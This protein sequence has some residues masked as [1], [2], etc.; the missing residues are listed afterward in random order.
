MDF[1]LSHLE[2]L[3]ER[4]INVFLRHVASHLGKCLKTAW[5]TL[6]FGDFSGLA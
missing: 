1:R 3:D 5:F 2:T 4:L 6:R